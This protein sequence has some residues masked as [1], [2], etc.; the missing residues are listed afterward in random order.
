MWFYVFVCLRSY[1]LTHM[2]NGAPRRH[3]GRVRREGRGVVRQRRR[4]AGGD[5]WRSAEDG[6]V[7]VYLGRRM[8]IWAYRLTGMC[9]CV[10]W[11]TDLHKVGV[12][13][14]RACVLHI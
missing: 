8:M 12:N 11:L 2:R 5:R 10:M 3:T 7:L 1:V 14:P 6:D 13:G 4:R 9:K